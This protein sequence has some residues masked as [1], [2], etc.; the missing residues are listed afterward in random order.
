MKN[1][2]KNLEEEIN[3]LIEE[4]EFLKMKSSERQE[5]EDS[6]VASSPRNRNKI[7]A[8]TFLC[9][10][11]RAKSSN[12]KNEKNQIMFQIKDQ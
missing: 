4:N 9:L 6:E 8:K 7:S 10:I 12:S 3:F 5:A 2:I 11:E 1:T